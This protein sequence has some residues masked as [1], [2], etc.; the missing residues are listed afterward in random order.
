MHKV[1]MAHFIL[2]K[3]QAV[4]E[5]PKKFIIS[6]RVHYN[7]V[8]WK[9]S[10]LYIDT[11]LLESK[12]PYDILYI[13]KKLR[14]QKIIIAMCKEEK[15]K[16]Y[17]LHNKKKLQSQKTSIQEI[18]NYYKQKP[19]DFEKICAEL[20]NKMGYMSKV[21]SPTNDG[22]YDIIVS[23]GNTNA[24]IEC[25]CYSIDNKIGRPAIQKLVG[26]NSI[27]RAT[28][29]IFITTSEFSASAITYAKQTNV[30]LIDGNDLLELLRKYMFID[31]QKVHVDR[32]E[33]QLEIEDMQSYV[34]SDIYKKYFLALTNQ[35]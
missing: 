10:S 18:I 3:I 31:R 34:P 5:I 35:K 24:I 13:V 23:R 30:E 8:C 11:S 6:I 4:E 9:T 25:K 28:R 16:Y 15:S 26:A 29:M 12:K 32:Q 17:M 21:T 1:I 19:T 22:G 33:W 20:Y 14:L 7:P 27:V 2:W